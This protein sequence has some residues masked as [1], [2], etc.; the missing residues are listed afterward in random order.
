MPIHA[1][2]INAK[3]ACPTVSSRSPHHTSHVPSPSNPTAGL[4]L[5]PTPPDGGPP[6]PVP[7]PAPA[8]IFG[9]GFG[10]GGNAPVPFAPAVEGTKSTSLLRRS[11]SSKYSSNALLGLTAAWRAF[12]V[13]DPVRA[14]VAAFIAGADAG[15]ETNGNGDA[16]DD[17]DA[18]T[19]GSGGGAAISA[20]T[21]NAPSAPADTACSDS[22]RSRLVLSSSSSA[23]T[24]PRLPASNSISPG[25]CMGSANG[26]GRRCR[27]PNPS[28]QPRAPLPPQARLGVMVTRRA[29]S[30]S[31]L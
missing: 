6:A 19:P 28:T 29:T 15:V 7:V 21:R 4:A 24:C 16:S 1:F 20:G 11:P 30:Y 5:L 25:A 12:R 26:A 8:P 18:G 17:D 27:A 2:L 9:G 3:Q 10:G 31:V 23:P 13:D 14:V 22:R